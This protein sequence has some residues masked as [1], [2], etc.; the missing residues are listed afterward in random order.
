MQI[1]TANQRQWAP[2]TFSPKEAK[3]FIATTAA[4]GVHPVTSHGSYLINLGSPEPIMYKRSVQAFRQEIQRCQALAIDKLVFHP[5]AAKSAS[6]ESCLA[7]IVQG[8]L[9]CQDL[10]TS[11]QKP[12]LLI[13]NTAGQG[14]VV[15]SH[16]ES[17]SYLVANTQA[18]LPIG[19]CLDTCHL[20]AAG[21]DIRDSASWEQLLVHFD[22]AIGCSYLKAL[23]LNDSLH[24]LGSRKDRHAPL[25]KGYIGLDCFAYMVQSPQLNHLPMYLETP[26]GDK[27]WKKEIAWLKEKAQ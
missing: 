5:G 10:F 3:N 14:T 1:F 25:G 18:K 15:G 17:L 2:A 4:L 8:L 7:R 22:Q 24:P 16:I 21:Y 12:T 13:E 27:L 11:Q 19:I 26:G 6:L 9:A 20:F 23:H